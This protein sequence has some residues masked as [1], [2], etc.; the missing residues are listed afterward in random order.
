MKISAIQNLNI[1][2]KTQ[3]INASK[4][5]VNNA[6]VSNNYAMPN[7]EQMQSMY[8]IS[9]TKKHSDKVKSEKVKKQKSEKTNKNNEIGLHGLAKLEGAE[10]VAA[11]REFANAHPKRFK[12]DMLVLDDSGNTP[13]IYAISDEN[14]LDKMVVMAESAP[15]EFKKAVLIKDPSGKAAIAYA[16]CSPFEGGEKIRA[17]TKYAPAEALKTMY[18]PDENGETAISFAVESEFDRID[19]SCAIADLMAIT[20]QSK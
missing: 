6:S 3:K 19:K 17:I 8:N 1:L 15:Q 18:S 5:T 20:P 11:L 4:K 10:S 7:L 14:G 13:L 2:Q 9:F 16:A 12:K